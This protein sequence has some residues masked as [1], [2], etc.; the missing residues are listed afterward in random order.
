MH[1]WIAGSRAALAASALLFAAAAPAQGQLTQVDTA[2]G[3]STAA[4]A[5]KQVVE[6]IEQGPA[7]VEITA[8]NMPQDAVVVDLAFRYR[9][10][11]DTIGLDELID[12][13][14]V[15][16]ETDAGE[17]FFASAVDAQLIHLNPNRVPLFYRVT[18]YRPTDT[19]HYRVRV[20][21]LGNY[22]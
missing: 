14:E 2:F 15:T 12:R 17:P 4:D 7:T 1:L 18:L 9:V 11:P 6:V 10:P 20:K 5:R 22:E 13:I 21:V 16:T 8:R 19:E 3:M